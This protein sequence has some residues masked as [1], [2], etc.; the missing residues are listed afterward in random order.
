MH[1][2]GGVDVGV[3]TVKPELYAATCLNIPKGRNET[4]HII[5]VT[6]EEPCVS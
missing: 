2:L 4:I 6:P 1:V 5:P 3:D